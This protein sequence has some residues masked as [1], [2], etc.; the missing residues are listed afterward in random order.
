MVATKKPRTQYQQD[1]DSPFT[2]LLHKPGGNKDGYTPLQHDEQELVPT[3]PH[4]GM[5]PDSSAVTMAGIARLLQQQLEPITANIGSLQTTCEH[6][7]SKYGELKDVVE[8]RLQR[9]ES[10]MD[11]SETRVDKLEEVGQ[12][13]QA[14][15]S[16][17]KDFVRDEVG[18][19][20]RERKLMCLL[21]RIWQTKGPSQQ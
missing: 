11:M 1:L 9:M 16:K 20:L 10:R 17:I 21:T 6:L 14:Q 5:S 7:T 3:C 8:A 19:G 18:T 13:F 15:I 4:P 2:P 12:Q